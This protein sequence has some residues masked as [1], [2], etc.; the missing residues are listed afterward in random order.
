MF[1]QYQ[2]HW[3]KTL[4][5]KGCSIS[6]FSLIWWAILNFFYLNVIFPK[7]RHSYFRVNFWYAISKTLR[8]GKQMHVHFDRKVVHHLDT[9]KASSS[10]KKV[11]HRKFQ[12]SSLYCI[13]C[14]HFKML[15]YMR[16]KVADFTSQAEVLILI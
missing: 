8:M 6:L 5:F 7:R 10:Q 11:N 14:E 16:M 9:D 15:I 3:L 2:Y 12:T 4:K 1:Y 13:M